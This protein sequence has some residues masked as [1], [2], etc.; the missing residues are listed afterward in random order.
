MIRNIRIFL[1]GIG[2][3]LLGYAATLNEIWPTK[4]LGSG[5]EYVFDNSLDTGSVSERLQNDFGGTP[6]RL[7]S[8]TRFSPPSEGFNELQVDGL[9]PR[10]DMPHVFIAPDRQPKLTF[11]HGVFDFTDG[12]HGAILLDQSGKVIQRWTLSENP[13]LADVQ[14]GV[15]KYPHGVLVNPDGTVDFTFDIG[16]SVSRV[17]VCGQDVWPLRTPM[18]FNHSLSRDSGG[19]IWSLTVT[20]PDIYKIDGDTGEILQSI[21]MRQILLAN[22]ILGIFEARRRDFFEGREWLTEPFHAN[23]VDPLTA[24]VAAA[25][26]MFNEGD[27]LLSFRSLN[28][29][30]VID[31]ETAVVKWWRAGATQR[32]HDPDW[33]ADGKFLVLDNQ[34]D[35]P[36]SRIVKIDPA[37]N[38]VEVVIDGA[39]YDFFTPTRGKVQAFGDNI[40]VTSSE[41]GRA[42]EVNSNGEIVFEFINT[43][44]AENRLR[45]FVSEAILLPLDY[46]QEFPTCPSAL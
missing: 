22:P 13:D 12:L 42:F 4:E 31:P 25:F 19:D 1:L 27:L 18:T 35:N 3:F 45:A 24:D 44:D 15:R 40:M 46:F 43:Y 5:W 8:R 17:D 7:L 38:L 14:A 20:V 29:L 26:P 30:F 10:R 23:D 9:R 11:L 36:P 37:T 2:V 28:L 39:D 21:T 33:G 34:R 41:Q 16:Q 32:Q 6:Y